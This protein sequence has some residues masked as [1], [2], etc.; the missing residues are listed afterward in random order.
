MN[1]R[2]WIIFGFVFLLVLPASMPAFGWDTI[3]SFGDSLSDDG[4]GL[5][6]NGVPV[7]PY[8]PASNGPVWLDYLAASMTDVV[9]E[10]R[11]IGG[12]QTSGPI[13]YGTDIGLTEQVNR[14][15][16]TLPAD[17][18][19][20]GIL[21]TVW[22][23]GNDFL[24]NPTNPFEAI[25]PAIIRIEVSVQALVDAGAEDILVMTLPDL[26]LAPGVS[27]QGPQASSAY[28]A[29]SETFND[30]LTASICNLRDINAGNVKFYMADTFKL[31]QYAV[32]NAAALGF[33]YVDFPC[34]W[35]GEGPECEG[36]IFYDGIHPTTA[37]HKFLAALALGQVKHGKVD[38]EMKD[39]LQSLN[40]I[41]PRKPF[42]VNCFE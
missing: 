2:R 26:G 21:F 20:G 16:N 12:A 14:Y 23:G 38:K 3:I 17:A 22:I 37:T 27:I 7:P 42:V 10:G 33:T 8:N 18:D 11:A 24:A 9:L 36:F 4:N 13:Y 40:P 29:A 31:L 28:T 5:P 1:K 32:E 15:I 34:Q 39:L 30:F 35:A 25:G 19:L 6:N 41:H